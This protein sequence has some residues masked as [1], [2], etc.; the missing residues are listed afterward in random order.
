MIIKY[1]ITKSLNK[2][3]CVSILNSLIYKTSKVESESHFFN[4]I[5]RNWQLL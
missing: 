3:T 1:I 5:V 2:L 4:S